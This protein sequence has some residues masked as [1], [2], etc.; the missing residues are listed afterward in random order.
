MLNAKLSEDII[1]GE[2]HKQNL[3]ISL[4]TQDLIA[5][6]QAGATDNIMRELDPSLA[7]RPIEVA[8]APVAPAPV[9]PEPTPVAKVADPNDPATAHSPG[10]YLYTEI[11]GKPK[12]VQLEKTV[13]QTSRAKM[14]G[15][16]GNAVYAFVPRDKAAIR[17]EDRQ[18]V[19]YM[20]APP[21]GQVGTT[22]DSPGQLELIRMEPQSIYGV[23]GRRFLYAKESHPF[24][25]P[26]VGTDPKA[27]R[28][29]RSEEKDSGIFRMMPDHSLDPGE[30]CFFF[31]VGGSGTQKGSAGNVIL[32]DFGVN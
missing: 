22:V 16:L 28:L 1:V 17:V 8:P 2:I 21:A 6:R 3:K 19:F 13:P 7:P 15:F 14:T 18:P 11:N 29:F 25:N 5:L 32:Y 9:Q 26:I 12:M 10:V 23:P 31:F 30:Y 24:S 4:T 27:I 20:Y